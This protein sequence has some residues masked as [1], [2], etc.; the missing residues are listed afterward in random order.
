VHPWE[1]YNHTAATTF[2]PV[3][4]ISHN[5]VAI[6]RLLADLFVE[7]H[8]RAPKQIILHLDATVDPLPGQQ[9]GR[10]FHGYYDCYCDLRLYVFCGGGNGNMSTLLVER[11][12]DV[13]LGATLALIDTAV[14]FPHRVD[15][16]ADG[17]DKGPPR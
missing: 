16:D 7:V 12:T 8:A 2:A 10:F 4:K 3:T 5:P 15:G 6:K 1:S 13:S 14:A 11:L 17:D 9:E